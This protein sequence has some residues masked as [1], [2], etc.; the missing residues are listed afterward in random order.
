MN[1]LRRFAIGLVVLIVFFSLQNEHFLS[2]SNL[3]IIA[4]HS[5]EVALPAL[6]MTFV[7]IAGG[8]DVSVGSIAA[9]CAV[10]AAALCTV[11]R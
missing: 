7:V 5:V 4:M 10:A 1:L 11:R 8:I 9:L 3:R 6:G 2:L